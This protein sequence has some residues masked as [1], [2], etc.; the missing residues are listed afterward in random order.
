M[1]CS[2]NEADTFTIS[3]FINGLG[4]DIM[5]EVLL[6]Y[7]T[8][9]EEAYHKILKIEKYFSSFTSHPTPSYLAIP[10]FSQSK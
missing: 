9:I 4:P 8:L 6:H 1:L 10:P 7:D 5:Q 3:R 2:I